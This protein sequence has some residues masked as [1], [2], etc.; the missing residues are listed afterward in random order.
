MLIG[1]GTSQEQLVAY[2]EIV[3]RGFHSHFVGARED[4]TQG[5]GFS[6]ATEWFLFSSFISIVS[7]EYAKEPSRFPSM[8]G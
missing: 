7:T 2:R 5:I 3:G 8:L 1:M 4:Y 6:L